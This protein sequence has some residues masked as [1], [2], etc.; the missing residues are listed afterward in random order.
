MRKQVRR[1]GRLRSGREETACLFHLRGLNPAQLYP[2]HRVLFIQTVGNLLEP[3]K[4]V[5]E[6]RLV[7]SFCRYTSLKEPQCSKLCGFLA[8]LEESFISRL[9][10]FDTKRDPVG[11]LKVSESPHFLITEDR[12]YSASMRF[13]L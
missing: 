2:L 9:C 7:K 4:K 3:S 12:L 11:F 8:I 6:N 10:T 1:R 5:A 13:P